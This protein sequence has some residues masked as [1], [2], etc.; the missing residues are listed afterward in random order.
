MIFDLDGTLLDTTEG[1][2][3]SI[4]DSVQQIDENIVLN[5][6]Q[7]RGFIGPSAKKS[8]QDICGLSL[9]A[10]EK[11]TQLYNQR[12]ENDGMFQAV[13][14]QGIPELLTLLKSRDWY[15]AVATLKDEEQARTMLRYFSLTKYFSHIMGA[16]KNH[17]ISKGVM[18][19]QILESTVTSPEKAVMIGDR[20]ADELGARQAGV[21]FIGVTYGFG[22][23]QGKKG[24]QTISLASSPA[25]ILT[26][27]NSYYDSQL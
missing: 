14:Y 26:L 22:F 15:L 1:L 27:L 23:Q 10:A 4:R 21:H 24:S 13:V 17:S 8:F 2:F 5:D 18:I 7:L 11:A 20:V 16:P 12:Y 25:E 3:Q 6:D 19:R 9:D